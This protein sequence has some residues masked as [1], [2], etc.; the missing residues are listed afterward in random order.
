MYKCTDCEKL[1]DTKPDYCECGNNTFEEIQKT[2]PA[3]ERKVYQNAEL[4]SIGIFILCIILSILSLIFIDI[5]PS[6]KSK[7]M[8]KQEV[9]QQIQNIPDI[10]K[11]WNNS[12]PKTVT[13]PTKTESVNIPEPKVVK[14]VETKEV[15]KNSIAKP[16]APKIKTEKTKS[17]EPPRTKEKPAAKVQPAKKDGTIKEE[18]DQ[19]EL[20]SYKINLR[21]ALFAY[22]SVPSVQG[23]GKCGIEFNISPAGKLTNRNF[24]FQSNNT[25]VNDAVYKMLMRMPQYYPPPKSYKGEK[26]KMTFYFNNGSYEI[27]YQ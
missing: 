15:K 26:I 2:K 1:F 10:E 21:R 25:S 20:I 19:N 24:T 12:V 5:K 22:L 7:N 6:D 13:A 27:N 4:I 9:K 16:S 18:V 3:S 23:E 14:T 17:T 8:Q 11:L